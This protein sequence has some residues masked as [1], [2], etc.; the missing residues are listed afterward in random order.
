[1]KSLKYL[2]TIY[3]MALSSA[4]AAT[5][6]PVGFVS[7]A[8][9][10]NSDVALGAPLGRAAEFQG[11]IQSISGNT[12]TFA[13]T[14][15]F[16]ANIFV[17]SAG[18]QAKTYFLRVDAGTKEGLI[19]PIVTNG[20]NSVEV[21]IPAGDDLTGI[22]TV[23][24]NGTGEQVSIA[25]YWTV[26]TLFSG[27]IAGTQILVT[28]SIAAGINLPTTTY[29]FNGTNW[30]KGPTPS[31]DDIL[32]VGQGLTVRNNNTT[33][34]L[35]LSVTGSVPMTAH[36]MRLSTLAANTRQDIRIFYNSPVPEIIGNVFNV[37]SLA[38]GDQLLYVNNAAAGKNKPTVTLVWNG[39]NWL[40]GPTPVTTTFTLLPGQSYLFRKNQSV[41]PSSVVW[42]DLQSYLE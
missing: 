21:T 24:A 19:L 41:S 16:G 12:V 18:V 7:V 22:N 6:A 14:P 2:A 40:Q 17:Y 34:P 36:R 11:V 23:L 32:L 38:P 33:T 25:P 37:G 30:L 39:T 10:A 4:M 28:S 42:T 5:T 29:T 26:G 35:T 31:N 20:T 3:A 27:A 1:M 9:P 13:G 15:N 8:V